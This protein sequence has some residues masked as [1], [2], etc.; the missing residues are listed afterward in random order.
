ME[1]ADDWSIQKQLEEHH[2]TGVPRAVTVDDLDVVCEIELDKA[3]DGFEIYG[4]PERNGYHR[5]APFLSG[6]KDFRVCSGGDPYLVAMGVEPSG[7][8]KN[9]QFLSAHVD[10]AFGVE[11]TERVQSRK[12]ASIR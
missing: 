5:E 7:F 11:N 9:T 4:A 12:R 3:P 10:G 1:R 2:R 6:L 8:L